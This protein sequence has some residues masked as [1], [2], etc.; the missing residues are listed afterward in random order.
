M[1]RRVPNR[2]RRACAHAALLLLAL[3]LSIP[4][5]AVAADP[6]PGYPADVREQARRVVE[7][8]RPGAEELLEPE[9]QALRKAMFDHAILSINVIPDT[10]FERAR[11]QGW[12]SQ[13][14]RV[15]RPITRV[16]PYSVPLWAWLIRDDVLTFGLE[17]LPK[18]FEGLEG[19]L[20][21]YPPGLLGCVAWILLFFAATAAWFA[22]WASI[23]MLFRAQPALAADV[24][25]VLKWFPRPEF[26]GFLVFLAFLGAPMVAGVGLA[27]AAVFW[28]FL[29]AGYLRRLELLTVT[30]AI[31]LLAGIFLSG[32]AFQ[33]IMSITGATRNGG[34]L[35]GEGHFPQVWPDA[36]SLPADVLSGRTW[37]SLVA[38]ARARAEMQAGNLGTAEQMWTDWIAQ[39]EDS[40]GGYNNRGIV[41][42]WLGKTDEAL[43]DFEKAAAETPNGGPAHWN[44]YQ[45]YLQTFRLEDAAKVQVAAWASLRQLKLFDYRAEEMTHGE[46]VP[47]PLHVQGLWTQ[48]MTP[49]RVWFREA[50]GSPLYR[51]FFRPLPGAWVVVFLAVGW[52]WTAAWKVLSSKVWMHSA[53][54]VCGTRTLVVGGREASDIC[55]PCRAQVGGG[56]GRGDERGQRVLNIVLHRRYVRACSVAIP[57]AG[58]LWAGKDFPALV[59]GI[60]LS[61]ALGAVTVTLG[62]GMGAPSLVSDMV[63]GIL[64][65]AAG[66]LVLLWAFGVFWGW[67]SFESLQLNYNVSMQR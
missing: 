51:F 49:S 41:R 15:L 53:C 34:W 50:A 58:V 37:E 27:V 23:S 10:V 63:R 43:A 39:A 42:V 2:S 40:S 65:A 46:L 52:I 14:G 64:I 24:G 17:R 18:D 8:A 13:A 12:K 47:S 22:V 54:R 48:L 30:L 61:V 19:A 6:F 20:V 5:R 56:L 11:R 36:G 7:A 4:S 1:T 32:G 44:A 60:F 67:R 9:V 33:S 3:L 31:V 57:G 66:A 21:Q 38:Y 35:G 28:F 26:V 45:M 29:A 62:A 55:N 16:A 25:R 59:Y